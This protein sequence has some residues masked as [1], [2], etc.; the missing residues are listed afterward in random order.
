MKIIIS[1]DQNNR[2]ISEDYYNSDNLYPRDYIIS[3]LKRAPKYMHG[4]IKNLPYI[5]CADNE[6][7]Q[8]VC[9]KIPDVVYQFLFGNF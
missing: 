7:T 4:Y 1:E 3:R 5:E 9:T 2:L 8:S 6:G